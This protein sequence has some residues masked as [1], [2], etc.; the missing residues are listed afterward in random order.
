MT[1][2]NQRTPEA[3]ANRL[4][5]AV[6]CLAL[7]S[8][9]AL[10]A[11]LR[12]YDLDRTSLW[13]DEIGS[14]RQASLPFLEM[15]A[16]T[17]RDNFPPLYNIILHFTIATI[18]DSEQALR[19]PSA[20]L[21]VTTVYL[22]YWLGALLWGRFTGLLAAL[23]L[24]LSGFHVWYSTEVRMYAL[25]AFLATAF[26]LSVFYAAERPRVSTLAANAAAGTA[27]L[28]THLYGGFAFVGVNI[29]VLL[30]LRARAEGFAVGS[31][32]WLVT[33][34]I[35]VVLFLPW[36]PIFIDRG[37]HVLTGFWIPQATPEFVLL[38]VSRVAGGRW[39]LL[40]LGAFALLSLINFEAAVGRAPRPAE[41]THRSNVPSWLRLDWQTGI[42]LAWLLVPIAAGYLISIVAQPI[43]L[44]RYLICSLPP[45]LLLAAHGLASLTRSRIAVVAFLG[46]AVAASFHNL[47]FQAF[48]RA[49]PD[50]RAAMREFSTRYEPSD[51]VLYASGKAA[52]IIAYYYRPPIL[53]LVGY[54]SARSIKLEDIDA[55]RFWLILRWPKPADVAAFISAARQQYDVIYSTTESDRRLQIYLFERRNRPDAG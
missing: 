39:A 43:F 46:L 52:P 41:E 4:T 15:I 47:R 35:P 26:V 3:R 53:H 20:L 11:W 8:V 23:L 2:I 14:W 5:F 33:Q 36:V 55:D 30:A 6:Q 7:G 13:Y 50:N 24:T 54:R 34:S 37:R 12:F 19:I 44:A 10:A 31:K 49:R 17:A 48:E 51:F 27:L 45:F 16:A 38:Q 1:P 29:A 28:Y 40:V 18:G 42:I 22:L 9:L 21:G 32:R 25:L